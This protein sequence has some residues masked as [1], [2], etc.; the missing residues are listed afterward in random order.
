LLI[1]RLVMASIAVGGAYL[2]GLGVA[3]YETAVLLGGLPIGGMLGGLALQLVYLG[4]A[5]ALVSAV[6][7]RSSSVIATIGFSVVVL[8]VLPAVGVIEG[9]GRWLPSHLVGAQVALLAEGSVGD[10]LPAVAVSVICGIALALLAFRRA[11]A[12]EL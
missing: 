9:I 1:P 5:V 2:I 7:A 8:L 11:E 10:Y 4:F 6:G 12:K 3:W